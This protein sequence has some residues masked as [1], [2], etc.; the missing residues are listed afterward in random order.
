MQRNSRVTLYFQT[1]DIYTINHTHIHIQT[2]ILTPH[3]F[4]ACMQ[5]RS[6]M[7]AMSERREKVSEREGE[8]GRASKSE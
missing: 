4:A 3:F 7:D 5:R 8:R 2:Y 6:I 1:T